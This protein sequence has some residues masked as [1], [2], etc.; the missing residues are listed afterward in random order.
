MTKPTISTKRVATWLTLSA[1]LCASAA[2][3]AS[4]AKADEPSKAAEVTKPAAATEPRAAVAGSVFDSVSDESQ[5]TVQD[6]EVLVWAKA[7]S[8]EC[9]QAHRK[10]SANC[11]GVTPCSAASVASTVPPLLDADGKVLC[12]NGL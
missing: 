1:A 11:C 2:G 4:A 6:R 10:A 7:F 3:V 8:A 9:T 5:L 12:P